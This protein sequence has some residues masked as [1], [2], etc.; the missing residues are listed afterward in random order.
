MKRKF[1]VPLIVAVLVVVTHILLLSCSKKQNDPDD[2]NSESSILK[3]AIVIHE[4]DSDRWEITLI[5]Q[6]VL[7][8]GD[9]S[10]PSPMRL[11][12]RSEASVLKGYTYEPNDERFVTS[13]GYTFGMPSASVTKAGQKT[14]Y[15]VL[16]LYR[17]KTV[18]D[19]QF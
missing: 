11:P 4:T 19:V 17:Y 2:P 3:S 9:L 6:H 18:I 13:D 14:K 15:S 7:Y 8:S 16:G 1:Y 12:D 10:V 5:R